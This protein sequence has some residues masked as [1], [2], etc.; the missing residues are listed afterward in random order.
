MR[1]VSSRPC[2]QEAHQLCDL[3]MAQLKAI[4]TR[5]LRGKEL[6]GELGRFPGSVVLPRLCFRPTN[7]QQQGAHGGGDGAG[8]RREFACKKTISLQRTGSG[9]SSL[10]A[11][12]SLL[13]LAHSHAACRRSPS[14]SSHQCPTIRSQETGRLR[15]APRA[16]LPPGAVAERPLP[17]HVGAPLLR[18]VPGLA[19]SVAAVCMAARRSAGRRPLPAALH[20]PGIA[21]DVL[22]Y[23]FT[24]QADGQG[25]AGPGQG[26]R[27]PALQAGR[28]QGAQGGRGGG[29]GGTGQRHGGRRLVVHEG[30]GG[31]AGISACHKRSCHKSCV[32]AAGQQPSSCAP[33]SK[34]PCLLVQT[35]RSL[36]AAPLP[37]KPQ[38]PRAAASGSR[39]AASARRQAAAARRSAA[40][41]GAG[42]RPRRRAAGRT[43]LA[44]RRGHPTWLP[45]GPRVR[46][47][48]VLGL[49]G[50][51]G[52]NKAA[53]SACAAGASFCFCLPTNCVASFLHCFGS[54]RRQEARRLWPLQTRAHAHPAAAAA[55]GQGR[56]GCQAACRV[57][58]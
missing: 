31:G 16:L 30:R 3:A 52:R 21:A 41:G 17:A 5:L 39:A 1:L 18:T 50:Q 54:P 26:R 12:P 6:P 24:P 58:R 37:P 7:L 45:Q 33:I 38:Q 2:V 48:W 20:L 40:A 32:A 57:L 55:R 56:G 4:S 43:A 23:G 29:G 9:H 47:L 53:C 25:A 15:P 27:P 14:P 28:Q 36:W 19:C 11:A 35:K 46:G 44:A 22:D 49:E 42:L 13:C 34:P 10:Q 51:Q 8:G